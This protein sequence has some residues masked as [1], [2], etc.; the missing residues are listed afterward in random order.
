LWKFGGNI[1]QTIFFKFQQTLK[2]MTTKRN[3]TSA[4]VKSI[5]QKRQTIPAAAIGKRV[6]FLLAGDGNVIDVKNKDGEL[7]QSVVEPGTVLQKRIYN[8]NANSGLA[9][10]NQRTRQYVLD[11]LAA[12]K[13]GNAEQASELFNEYLNSTQM[14]FGILLPSAIV[15]K[16]TKNTE[17]VGTVQR[18]DTD[19]GS[20]LTI[21]PTTI[22]IAEPESYGTTSFNLDDF[23]TE[24]IEGPSVK[25]TSRV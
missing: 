2:I 19:N 21:D 18:I 7:V 6:K 23:T 13:A 14:S 9:M 25:E 3:M 1:T 22:S 10:Q 17:I 15:T 16:L 5:M 24:P 20:L 11:G 12:E 4:S 8:L